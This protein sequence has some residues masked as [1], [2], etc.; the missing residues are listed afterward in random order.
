MDALRFSVGR[1]RITPERV[2]L[3]AQIR[4]DVPQLLRNDFEQAF[5]VRTVEVTSAKPLL[6]IEQILAWADAH[7]ATTGDWPNQ[8]SGQVEATDEMWSRIDAA[9]RAGWANQRCQDSLGRI[10]GVRTH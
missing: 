3:P 9:L 1:R 5:Y 8:K 2:V 4:L 10:K 7:Q 6:T